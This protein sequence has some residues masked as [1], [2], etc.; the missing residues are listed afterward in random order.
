MGRARRILAQAER[1][2]HEI[3]GLDAVDGRI[4]IG[5]LP[6]IAPYFLSHALK[7]FSE[8]CLKTYLNI[9]E[10]TKA[11]LLQEIEA[12]KLDFGIVTL[13]IKENGFET[14]KLFLEELVL[15]LPAQHELADWPKIRVKDLYSEN[16]IL[17]HEGDFL[18]D[19]ALDFCHKRNFRPRIVIQCGQL[20]TLQ[21]FVAEG[22][23]V[24]LVPQMATAIAPSHI[25]YFLQPDLRRS[26]CRHRAVRRQPKLRVPAIW[27]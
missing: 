6:T 20:V 26:Q 14:E 3:I 22:L 7:T 9:H 8:R 17:M 18:G 27:D 1:A 15:A 2:K 21:S 19:Q 23:G 24:S 11:Q 12:N 10:E 16:F 13:P 25:A 5:I 4:S